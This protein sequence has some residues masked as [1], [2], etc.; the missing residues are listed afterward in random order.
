MQYFVQGSEVF[1]IH[2]I[3]KGSH[4]DFVIDPDSGKVSL[5]RELN[6][7]RKNR[8]TLEV[9][10]VDG[11]APRALTGTATLVSIL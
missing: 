5:L 11:G 1:R 6:Y 2:R 8:Y 3:Q 7:D 10:A 4:D 9:V